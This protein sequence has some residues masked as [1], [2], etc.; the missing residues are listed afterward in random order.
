MD[1][2]GTQESAERDELWFSLLALRPEIE[3]VASGELDSS[4]RE[5][6]L[7]VLL[8]RIVLRELNFRLEGTAGE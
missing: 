1:S 7:F 8:A 5:R 2:N 3:R 6:Q 4:D